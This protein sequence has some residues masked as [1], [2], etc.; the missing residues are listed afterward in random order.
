MNKINDINKFIINTMILG[1]Y[2]MQIKFHSTKQM[3]P[4]YGNSYATTYYKLNNKERSTMKE[5]IEQIIMDVAICYDRNPELNKWI[6]H[7]LK[8]FKRTRG[9]PGYSLCEILGDLNHQINEGKDI[10]SGMMGRY[11]RLFKDTEWDIELVS[12]RKPSKAE[13]IKRAE[14]FDERSR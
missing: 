3:E 5:F 8:K 7:P 4:R 10:P 14:L 11:N 9:L 12:T 13:Q 2:I 6:E 1:E